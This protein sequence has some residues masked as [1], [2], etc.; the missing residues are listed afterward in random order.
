MRGLFHGSAIIYAYFIDHRV[1]LCTADALN[2]IY[3]ANAMSF[4]TRSKLE[5]S[6]CVTR[7]QDRL[8]G[9][10]ARRCSEI[11]V[12]GSC[13]LRQQSSFETRPVDAPSTS[14]LFRCD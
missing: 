5:M 3:D 4:V 8:C 11:R 1:Q 9:Q 12:D 6:V 14:T 10:I 7:E 13:S 2:K